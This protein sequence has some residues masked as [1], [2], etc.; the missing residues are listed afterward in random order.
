MGP[1]PPEDEKDL[2]IARLK[3]RV[4]ELEAQVRDLEERIEAVREIL[5]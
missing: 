3:A 4:Q 1:H 2:E 5:D